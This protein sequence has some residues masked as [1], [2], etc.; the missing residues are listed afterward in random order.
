MLRFILTLAHIFEYFESVQIVILVCSSI[1]CF[2]NIKFHQFRKNNIEESR[3][4]KIIETDAWM[5]REHY[6]VHFFLNALTA[7]YLQAVGITTECLTRFFLNL[8]IELS[9][10]SHTAKHAQRVVG[11]SDIWIK[12]CCYNTVFHIKYA[13]KW[14]N[15]F[16][17][18][19]TVKT[20]CQR[21]NGEITTVLVVFKSSIFN[22]RLTAIVTI[23]FLSGT[24]KFHLGILIF[25]LS[26]SKIAEHRDMSFLS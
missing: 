11:K 15:E 3:L 8:K 20:N 21:I 13:I 16:T 7:Y 19:I 23:A 2:H 4:T 17:E 12:R 9:G 24:N 18:A 10:K 5:R 14:V 6:L 1:A 26:S 22:M 25:H